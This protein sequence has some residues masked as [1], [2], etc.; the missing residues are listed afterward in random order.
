M[1]RNSHKTCSGTVTQLLPSAEQATCLF[2]MPWVCRLIH[3]LLIEGFS[4]F[5]E[6]YVTMQKKN[7]T[8]KALG[9]FSVGEGEERE[10]LMG[11]HW[12]AI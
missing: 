10:A 8:F 3:H 9:H 12:G 6:E 11:L 7:V 1:N 2:P 5:V 4:Y